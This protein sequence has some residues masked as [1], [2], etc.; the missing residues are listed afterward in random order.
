MANTPRVNKDDYHGLFFPE[1]QTVIFDAL[2]KEYLSQNQEEPDNVK[3]DQLA[4]E[5]A[6]Q[7]VNAL[8]AQPPSP[9]KL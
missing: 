8:R 6:T 3:L 5:A 7:I 1:L 2:R 4:T 9:K